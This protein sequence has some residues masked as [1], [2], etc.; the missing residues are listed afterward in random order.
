[1]GRDRFIAAPL[2]DEA[3]KIVP[4]TVNDREN[5]GRAA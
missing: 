3:L 1:M 4:R 2:F 5:T